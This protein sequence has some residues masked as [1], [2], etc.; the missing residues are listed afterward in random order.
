[1]TPV[2]SGAGAE[3]DA[4]ARDMPVIVSLLTGGG[5]R[6]RVEASSPSWDVNLAADYTRPPAPN[7]GEGAEVSSLCSA[8]SME[9]RIAIDQFSVALRQSRYKI[10]RP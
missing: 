7:A 1:M 2:C 3:V 10:S 5:Y 4:Y 9:V 8:G 6:L